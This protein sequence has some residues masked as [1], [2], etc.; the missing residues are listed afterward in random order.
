[1]RYLRMLTNSMMGGALGA[2]YIVILFVELNPGTTPTLA[3]LV[4]LSGT[5]VL[6]Y[7]LNLTVVFYGLI[8]LGQLFAVEVFSPGWLSVRLLAWLST[9]A[10]GAATVL[11][12]LNAQDFAVALE[13]HTFRRMLQIAVILFSCTLVMFGVAVLQVSLSRRRSL[14][15]AFVLMASIGASV[16]VPLA[17]RSTASSIPVES[18]SLDVATMPSPSG[19]MPRV[20]MLILDGASLDYI[21]PA[22]AEGRLP[23]FG[24]ILDTGAALHLTTIRPTQPGPVWTAVATGKLP[25]KNGVRSAATYAAGANVGLI[26]LLPDHCFS[27]ALVHLGFLS[28][29]PNDSSSVRAPPLWTILSSLGISV[30]IVG[31]PLSHPVAPVRGFLI[32]DRFHVAEAAL[33]EGGE[34]RAAYPREALPAAIEAAAAAETETPPIPALAGLEEGALQQVASDDPTARDR[35]YGRVAL[36]LDRSYRPQVLAVRYQGLDAVGHRFLRYAMPRSFGDVSEQERRQYGDVLERYYAFVDGAVGVALS[37]LGVNDLLL[38][39]SGF[40]ME[41]VSLGKRLLAR[42]IG[43]PD[44]SGTHER[45]PDGFMLAYG[46]NVA[47][48][49]LPLGSIIDVLPTV[50][51]FLGLPVGRDMDGYARTDLFTRAYTTERPITFIPTYEK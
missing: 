17:L 38:V 5:L 49:K 40:G 6:F 41:P 46:A 18:K 24:R 22:A 47:P 36:E 19:P 27:R 28:E 30:G 10:C 33:I 51:Y 3:S 37:S 34:G 14:L 12:W 15:A 20:V 48:G 35:L 25:V 31:W 1:M 26:E 9:V 32:S 21:T 23:N 7:G 8:V 13:E 29:H 50:L 42:A 44:L 39:V 11:M 43:D 45:A 16:A 4:S 2:A